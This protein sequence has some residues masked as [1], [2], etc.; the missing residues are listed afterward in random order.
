M[1]LLRVAIFLFLTLMLSACGWLRGGAD[2][3]TDP[4]VQRGAARVLDTISEQLGRTSPTKVEE[5]ARETGVQVPAANQGLTT[6]RDRTSEVFLAVDQ[7][8]ASYPESDAQQIVKWACAVNDAYGIRTAETKEERERQAQAV[9]ESNRARAAAVAN[10]VT[11]WQE[12]FTAKPTEQDRNLVEF[13]VAL[14]CVAA[15]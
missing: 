2:T 10:L 13:E 9:G 8:V 3:A 12:A 15:T 11:S 1:R 5:V 4:A 6:L 7:A 14:F